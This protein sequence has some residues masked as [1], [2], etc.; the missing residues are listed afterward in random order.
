MPTSLTPALH[1]WVDPACTRARST[2]PSF[3][4]IFLS[5]VAG[6]SPSSALINASG[7]FPESLLQIMTKG[8]SYTINPSSVDASFIRSQF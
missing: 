1:Y 4:F 2:F 7:L 8:E 5:Q 3:I 6:I